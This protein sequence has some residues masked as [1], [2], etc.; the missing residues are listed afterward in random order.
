MVLPITGPFSQEV[1]GDRHVN[2]GGFPHYWYRKGRTW[3]RQKR[4]Y[5]LPLSY[6][7]TT[8]KILSHASNQAITYSTYADLAWPQDSSNGTAAYN[9][10]YEKFKGALGDKA[11]LSISLAE[12]TQAMNMIASRFLQMARFTK[13]LK[14]FRFAAAAQI[15]GLNYESASTTKRKRSDPIRWLDRPKRFPGRPI[16]YENKLRRNSKAFGDNYLEFHF[17]WSPLIGDI[18]SAVNVLQGGVP[19][20]VVRASA[21]VS[22]SWSTYNAP[23]NMTKKFVNKTTYR[24]QAEVVINNPNL[25]LAN[26]LGFVNPALVAFELIS[27][28]FLLD[29]VANI[30]QFLSSFTDFWG[31]TFTNPQRTEF[32]VQSEDSKRNYTGG[33]VNFTGTST[34][35]VRTIGS[36]PGPVL[37][38]RQPY[39][40][41]ARRG[42]AAVSL[43]LQRLK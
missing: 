35:M 27:F 4:P 13:E 37:R 29:W 26:Q 32:A 19:P 21:S 12:R 30:S 38:F 7:A 14:R 11:E 9:K 5:N 15:L 18:G 17:G 22:R 8:H 33:F 20:I 39:Q 41:S 42:L 43:L 36:F 1:L 34:Y 40:L 24:M 16:V 31:L 3:S 28:S 23:S 6:G 25:H 2:S 10:C